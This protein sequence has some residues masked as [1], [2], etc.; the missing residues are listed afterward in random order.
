MN[1]LRVLR[2]LVA[3]WLSSSYLAHALSAPVSQTTTTLV[4]SGTSLPKTVV[5][6]NQQ[7]LETKKFPRT[8]VPIASTYELDPDRPT[9]VE[10]LGQRYA[11]YRD[12]DENWVV[13][14]NTCPHRLAPLSEGRI[15]R[16]KNT[17]QCSYHGWEFDSQGACTSIPQ[18]TASAEASAKASPRSCVASYPVSVQGKVVF[19]WPWKED[20]LST[21]SKPWACPEGLLDGVGEVT[22]TFTRDLPYG[23]D[24][25]V[26]NLIDPSH[27]P[28]AHHGMQGTRDDAVAINMTKPVSLGEAGFQ[29]EWGDRTMKMFRKGEGFFKAPMM[30][31]YEADFLTEAPRKFRLSVFCVPIRPGWSRVILLDAKDRDEAG[32]ENKEAQKVQKKIPLK[33]RLLVKIFKSLPV[34]LGHQLSNRFFDSDLAFLHFQEQ[35]RHRRPQQGANYY[36]PAPADRCVTALQKWIPKYTNI[37]EEALPLGPIPRSVLFDRDAQHTSHCVH[38]QK[39]QA[40]IQKWRKRTYGILAASIL[41]VRFRIARVSLLCCLGLLKIYESL[42]KGFREGDFKHYLNH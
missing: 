3:V 33:R 27:V 32:A 39:G 40:S 9:P 38:C 2:I 10:F 21:A 12:N 25:L 8:W 34:W 7:A 15:N 11:V 17:I 28:F 29:F 6:A 23:W 22:G 16:E 42:E 30:V 31:R 4:T 20:V 19:V 26:E 13:V 1:S 35:E 5:S 36:M 37:T 14:D 24:T 18:V 41:G